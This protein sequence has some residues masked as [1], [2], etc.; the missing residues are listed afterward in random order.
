MET[1][2]SPN[3]CTSTHTHSCVH[4]ARGR[5]TQ[6]PSWEFQPLRTEERAHHAH[7]FML[8]YQDK[9]GNLLHNY[10]SIQF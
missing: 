2:R 5:D 6:L 1:A 9:L 10:I 7:I 8:F 3:T 4:A